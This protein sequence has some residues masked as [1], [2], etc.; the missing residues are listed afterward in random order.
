MSN[1]TVSPVKIPLSTN[2]MAAISVYLPNITSLA[3]MAD[4]INCT[5]DKSNGAWGMGQRKAYDF[6]SD[7]EVFE[8]LMGRLVIS[9]AD[10]CAISAR[11][12]TTAHFTVVSKVLC[13]GYVVNKTVS[14]VL[15]NVILMTMI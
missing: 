15:M 4:E 6:L 14:C 7:N 12:R 9:R 11:R 13:S 2:G 3:S 1:T 8:I 10:C 5:D